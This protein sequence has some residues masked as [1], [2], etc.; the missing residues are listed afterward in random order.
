[1]YILCTACVAMVLLT[2]ALPIQGE[3]YFGFFVPSDLQSHFLMDRTFFALRCKHLSYCTA[4]TSCGTWY[5]PRSAPG[6]S[7][8]PTARAGTPLTAPTPPIPGATL[9]MRLCMSPA[10]AAAAHGELDPAMH[11]CQS[12]TYALHII[13]C[14]RTR[15]RLDSACH[16]SLCNPQD[17]LP[18]G[19][20]CGTTA[21]AG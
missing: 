19:G 16:P 15:H 12:I 21:A 9:L 4:S 2:D 8:R 3:Y 11:A 18:R 7:I 5:A 6:A 10:G 13:S 1:M 14:C 17:V 20:C